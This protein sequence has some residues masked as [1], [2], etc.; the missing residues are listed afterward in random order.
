MD[1]RQLLQRQ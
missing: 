1:P